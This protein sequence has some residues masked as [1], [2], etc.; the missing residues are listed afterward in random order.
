MAGP[1][2]Y[3]IKCSELLI[4]RDMGKKKQ[5]KN[6][7]GLR[8]QPKTASHIKDNV[9]VATAPAHPVTHADVDD[10]SDNDEGWDPHVRLDSNRPCWDSDD[11]EKDSEDEADVED[12]V[13]EAGEDGWRSESLQVGLMV[14]AIEIGDDPRDEDWIPEAVRR[15]HK[16]RMAQARPRP[17]FYQKGPDVGSKSDRTQRRYTD[18]LKG[19]QTLENL[20]FV[21]AEPR[22]RSNARASET[23]STPSEDSA[24]VKVKVEDKSPL[25]S[26]CSLA[27]SLPTSELEDGVCVRQE[28]P[29]PPVLEFNVEIRQ[30]SLTPPPLHFAESRSPSVRI[31]EESVTPPPLFFNRPTRK[32]KASGSLES[33]DSEDEMMSNPLGDNSGEQ[34]RV[35]DLQGEESA[36]AW[37]EE[38][39]ETLMP[40]AEIQDWATLRTQI[41]T[42]LKKK[43]KSMTL[44]QINQLMLLWN[45]ANLCLK[46]FAILIT[47]PPIPTGLQDSS[48]IP[49]GF[50]PDFDKIS[51]KAFSHISP[52]PLLL[53]SYWTPTGLKQIR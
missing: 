31:R 53:D 51:K 39:D 45:F 12:E 25:I 18:L 46:G 26:P 40:N 1:L 50:L 28:T 49:T 21:K 3:S 7:T 32:R 30:E 10:Q 5:K 11:E 33:E 4:I 38:L 36:D 14:L 22:T 37:E 19:Q 41:K 34:Q 43:H 29:D 24:G 47:P 20:G 27:S 23:D 13:I 35:E 48:R 16:A 52:F 44:S 42:D 17:T 15:K 9:T 6:I 2:K 8:N